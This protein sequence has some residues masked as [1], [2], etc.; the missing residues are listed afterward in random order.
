MISEGQAEPWEAVTTPPNPPAR[1][2]YSCLPEQVIDTYNRC[3]YWVETGPVRLDAYLFWG[4]E[5]W[6]LR[7][8]G[9]D[10]RYLQAFS[11]ILT[12]A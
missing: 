5:Y 12:H 6:V 1:G 4:A 3:L 2:T 7:Q 8:Q 10:E 9:G 11:R